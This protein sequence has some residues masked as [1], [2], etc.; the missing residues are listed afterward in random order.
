[1]GISFQL[2]IDLA[3]GP[4]SSEEGTG[5]LD[6]DQQSLMGISIFDPLILEKSNRL[7]RELSVQKGSAACSK[8]NTSVTARFDSGQIQART[9]KSLSQIAWLVRACYRYVAY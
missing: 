3:R 6:L 4:H 5:S 9:P 2:R 8:R 7:R 1:M